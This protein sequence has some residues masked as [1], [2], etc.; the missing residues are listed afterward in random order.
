MINLLAKFFQLF[1]AKF[2]ALRPW[3]SENLPKNTRTFYQNIEWIKAPSQ[4]EFDDLHGSTWWNY[5]QQK[6][7]VTHGNLV[8]CRQY[9]CKH[10]PRDLRLCF[11]GNTCCTKLCLKLISAMIPVRHRKQTWL[12]ICQNLTIFEEIC[13]EVKVSRV[14]ANRLAKILWWAS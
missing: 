6:K 7:M 2:K 3:N 8:N 4:F 9:W 10:V 12:N 1:E 5:S 13:E 14:L 11:G